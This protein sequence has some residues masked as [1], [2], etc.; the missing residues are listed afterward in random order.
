MRVRARIHVVLGT[1]LLAVAFWGLYRDV[2]WVAQPFYAWVWWGYILILDGFLA[3]KRGNSLLTTRLRYVFP[4]CLWSISF[5]FF[6]ELINA[7]IQNW[8]YVGVY[9]ASEGLIGM[10]FTLLAFA[11]V[12][13][14]IFQTYDALTATGLWKRWKRKRRHYSRRLTY[15]LQAVGLLTGGLALL[16]PYYFAPLVWGSFTLIVDPWN[17]RRGARSLLRDLENG[18]YGLIAR[19]LLAGL[20]C[21][22]V[23]ESLN[24]LAP[25]KWIYTVRGLEGFKVFEMPL[26]GFLGFPAL[27]LD[28]MAAFAL[29]ASFFLGNRSWERLADLSYTPAPK[30]ASRELSFRLW[31]PVHLVFWAAVAVYATPVNIGSLQL[32]LHDVQLTPGEYH[33]LE[34]LGITRPRQ[35]LRRSAPDTEFAAMHERLGWSRKRLHEIRDRIRLYTFKGIGNHH[36]TRLEAVGI[37]TPEDLRHWTPEALHAQIG[38]PPGAMP[39]FVP[40]LDFVRVWVLAARSRAG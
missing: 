14:G 28:T 17:Y 21:G 35:F 2:R 30:R 24:F 12:F 40:R 26:L 18:D 33:Q 34:A 20:V 27:A 10:L 31:V 16:Y 22:V 19:L 9:P 7:R 39:L 1:L 23:W 38:G 29:L 5:W 15:V 8:Y 25:Q 4:I 6:F 32:S 36:G 3:W 13:M 11:T 37:R